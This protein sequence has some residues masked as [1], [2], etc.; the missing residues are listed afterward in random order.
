MIE[1]SSQ[2]K[3]MFNINYNNNDTFSMPNH[4][5]QIYKKNV[6]PRGEIC[7]ILFLLRCSFANN[8]FIITYYFYEYTFLKSCFQMIYLFSKIQLKVQKLLLNQNTILNK[9]DKLLANDRSVDNCLQSI[10]STQ[11]HGF[12]IHF[13]D[14]FPLKE[15]TQFHHINDIL[16]NK[17]C[18]SLM[19][20]NILYA[21]SIHAQYN[22]T[23]NICSKK[24]QL[25]FNQFL[26][27]ETINVWWIKH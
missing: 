21:N 17:A 14:N 7:K 16:N 24:N 20:N 1:T 15:L 23:Y 11:I 12:E 6:V 9:L 2:C 3:R 27:K 4:V 8:Y 19:A 25:R 26:E 5:L 10:T 18:Y 22:I 13:N